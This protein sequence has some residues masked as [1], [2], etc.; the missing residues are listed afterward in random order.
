MFNC[1]GCEE[2][3]RTIQF[4]KEQNKDLMDRL[5][6]FSKDALVIYNAEKQPKEPLFP[7]ATDKDGKVFTYKDM[8]LHEAKDDIFRAFGEE[9]VTVEEK[10][11]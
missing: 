2:K 6:A 11:G 9:V 10:A 1:K 3:E 7:I 5:M 4:L 8:N